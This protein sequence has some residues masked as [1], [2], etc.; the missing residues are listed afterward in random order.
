MNALEEVVQ[1]L[2]EIDRKVSGMMRSGVVTDVDTRKHL[3]RMEIG[4]DANGQP[5]KGPWVPYAQI[6]GKL[7]VH[8]PPSVGQQMV[9]LSPSGDPAQAVAMPFTWSNSNAAPSQSQSENVIQYGGMK[10]TLTDGA[11]AITGGRITHDGKNIGKDH[12]HGD[13]EPGGGQTGD[14]V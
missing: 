8:T 12:K 3:V 7:K 6:A 11:L 4:R 13:V 2:A 10:F 1:R 14:P 9:A 5:V